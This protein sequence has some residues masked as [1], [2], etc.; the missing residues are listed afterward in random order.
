MPSS[1]RPPRR[2]VPGLA[3]AAAL[4]AG[5]GCEIARPELPRFTTTLTVPLGHER[6]TA[7]EIAADE[8]FL[9]VGADSLLSLA[10]SGGSDTLR[11]A[12]DLSAELPATSVVAALGGFAPAGGAPV[13]FDFALGSVYPAAAP[14]DGATVAVPPFTF[15]LDGAPADLPDILAARVAS[16]R[17]EV[18]VE[19]GL[20]VA[21]SDG[22]PPLRVSVA[23]IDPAT[24]AALATVVFPAPIAAGAAATAS[25]D[26][27]GIALP[28]SVGVRLAGGSPGSADPVTIDADA[29]LRLSA[30]LRDLRL[31]GATALV[32]PQAFTAAATVA[33]PDS[34]R[35]VAA[36]IAEG[37]LALTLENDL[38]IPCVA[39]LTFPEIEGI[40]GRPLATSLSLPAHGSGARALALAGAR[41]VAPGATPLAALRCEATVTSAGSGGLPVTLDAADAL[42]AT[43]APSRLR[44]GAVT[45]IIPERRF[46][47][48]PITER[49]D[50]PDELSGVSLT[51]ASLT[52]TVDSTVDL[53]ARLSATLTGRSAAGATA[54]VEVLRDLP[55]ASQPDAAGGEIVLDG[56]NS[57]IVAFLNNLPTEITLTG[58][59]TV[60]GDGVV[61]TVRP[62]DRAVIGWRLDAP[63]RVVVQGA[64]VRGDPRALAL[65]AEA[66]DRLAGRLGAVR[67][68]T[69]IANH[70]PLGVEIR[71][72]VGDD[73]AT[74]ADAP[75]LVVGPLTA[76]AGLLDPELLTVRGAAVTRGEVTL[77]AAQAEILTRAGLQ[78]C[79]EVTLPGTDGRAVALRASDWLTVTGCV[80]IELEVS[81]DD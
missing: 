51:S 17:L 10:V 21:V 56:D 35:V 81:D 47:I 40:D 60:G 67:V 25:A 61:G 33:L 38:A 65:D 19:N 58:M 49:L 46:A 76:A 66:R 41:L 73:P 36:E 64:V 15:D 74:L 22:G 7:A 55:A 77:T 50:L 32:G 26:L 2:L 57:D 23:L 16:G 37:T 52:L 79:V 11:V 72:L 34:V 18:T 43:L 59:V 24:G 4:V 5:A 3:L 69:D 14:L 29:R 45:G 8:A 27:A 31:A 63:L 12:A 70:L 44:F 71:L 42:R 68:V 54:T 20:P 75:L 48:A 1:V 13:R 9:D 6:V 80:E 53:P 78:T 30:G 62:G 28:D 39:D